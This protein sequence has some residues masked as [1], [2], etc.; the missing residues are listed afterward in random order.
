[1]KVDEL[2]EKIKLPQEKK[3]KVIILFLLGIFF[4]LAATPVASITKK[5]ENKKTD[6][7]KDNTEEEVKIS[8]NDEYIRNLENKLEQTI[9]GME[10]AGK[11][12]V[13]VT[14]KDDGEKI[15]DKNQPYESESDMSKEEGKETE[16]SI[17]K[18]KQETVLVEEEN[19]TSPIVVQ[20]IYPEIK[21]VVIVC[22]GGDNKVLSLQIKEAVQALFSIDAHNIVVCKLNSENN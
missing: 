6:I 3:E 12:L 1:M 18:S 4:L 16:K 21:G 10:G 5:T 20:N 9:G 14:L 22:E 19:N 13:M 8:E 17:M 15:L 11:V 7:V 2:K